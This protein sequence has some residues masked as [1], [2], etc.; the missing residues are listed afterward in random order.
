M[1]LPK[2]EMPAIPGDEPAEG[3]PEMEL[4]G[5]DRDDPSVERP[6]T[7]DPRDDRPNDPEPPDDPNADLPERLGR[8][9]TEG[10]NSGIAR[11]PANTVP[12]TAPPVLM[13]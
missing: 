7:P 10:P 8:R 5:A 6:Y 1:Q 13:A 3:R 12:A 2:P 11:N 9:I 4:P